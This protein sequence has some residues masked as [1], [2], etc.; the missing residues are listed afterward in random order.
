MGATDVLRSIADA[1]LTVKV[2]GRKL[3]IRPGS[4]LTDDLRAA[5]KSAGPELLAMLTSEPPRPF[6]LSAEDRARAHDVPWADFEITLYVGR[7]TLFMRRGLNATD[8]NDL[9]EQRHFRD[10]V[11][12]DRVSCIECNHYKPGTTRA[13]GNVQAAGVRE[14]GPATATML[15]G[16][17]GFQAVPLPTD[18]DDVE[19]GLGG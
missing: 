17:E 14:C 6:A 13:C 1:G 10:L 2:H 5:I 15:Q 3:V 4:L 12:D 18:L 9:A 8:A 19:P 7:M 16:C 11:L